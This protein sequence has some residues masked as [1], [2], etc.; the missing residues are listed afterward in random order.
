MPGE[1][2]PQPVEE[3]RRREAKLRQ[4]LDLRLDHLAPHDRGREDEEKD[5]GEGHRGEARTGGA[6]GADHD[7]GHQRSEERQERDHNEKGAPVGHRSV[8]SLLSLLHR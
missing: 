8:P 1:E 7:P 5:E 6:A 2:Q 4:P 3:E